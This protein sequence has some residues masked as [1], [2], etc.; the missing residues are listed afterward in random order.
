MKQKKIEAFILIKI[1]GEDAFSFL[2]S[3]LTQDL[4]KVEENSVHWSAYCS[5]KGRVLATFLITKQDQDYLCITHRSLEKVFTQK[6]ARFILRA[7]V[8]IQVLDTPLYAVIPQTENNCLSKQNNTLINLPFVNTPRAISW[9]DLS[10]EEMTE[11]DWLHWQLEN[12][13]YPTPW[14]H[15]EQENT[16]LTQQLNLD[17]HEIQAVSFTKG[18]YTGQEIVAR[19][20]Y[21]A[22]LKRRLFAT[23]T[24]RINPNMLDT[25]N[26]IYL[27]K[28]PDKPVGQV[29][30]KISTNEYTYA[31]VECLVTHIDNK[32]ILYLS[33]NNNYPLEIIKPAYDLKKP[34][35]IKKR[36]SLISL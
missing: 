10:Y 33:N 12:I 15:Q 16:F 11:N 5:A 6:L 7:N 28:N 18:C 13:L 35:I 1:T 24:S 34:D 29:L 2:Q 26:D 32:E 19:M 22:P 8:K 9:V 27:E 36:T 25:Y 3:Q 21:K 31:L 14:I 20:H 23:R 30:Q 4:K 17:T